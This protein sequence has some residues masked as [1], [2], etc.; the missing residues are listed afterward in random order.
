MGSLTSVAMLPGAI[1]STVGPNINPAEDKRAL[2]IKVA[3]VQSER[4]EGVLPFAVEEIAK[5]LG[6]EVGSHRCKDVEEI[7][8]TCFLCGTRLSDADIASGRQTCARC[9]KSM[10]EQQPE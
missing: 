10:G 3:Q 8:G 2:R 5:H 4:P 1:N 6:I 9:V 7:L